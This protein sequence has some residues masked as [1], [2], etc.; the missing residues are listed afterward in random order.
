MVSLAQLL[1]GIEHEHDDD[2]E[3]EHEHE[4]EIIAESRSLK[5]SR[6]TY[7]RTPPWCA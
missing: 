6:F 5:Q 1:S 4:H 3:S 2:C 7:C